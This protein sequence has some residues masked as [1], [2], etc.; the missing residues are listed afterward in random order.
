MVLRAFSGE[1]AISCA[2]T[3]YPY[4]GSSTCC[5]GLV[6][7]GLRMTNSSFFAMPLLHQ[8]LVYP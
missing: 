8:E 2:K 3:I 6:A 1:D 5:Q 7:F 4:K